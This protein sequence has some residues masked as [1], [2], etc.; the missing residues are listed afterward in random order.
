M[1]RYRYLL[2][3]STIVIDGRV[4]FIKDTRL[5]EDPRLYL[6]TPISTVA[7]AVRGD[8][9]DGARDLMM[10]RRGDNSMTVEL[11]NDARLSSV[12]FNSVGVG[13][14]VVGAGV[15]VVAIV[16]S[17]AARVAGRPWV[18]QGFAKEKRKAVNTEPPT[19][20]QARK[21]W[22]TVN[23]EALHH[24]VKYA[25]VAK[26]G[27]EELLAVRAKLS[28]TKDSIVAAQAARRI[29]Y[30]EDLVADSKAEVAKVDGLYE[31]WSSAHLEK[32][33]Q[34][35]VFTLAID[36]LPIHDD[37]SSFVPAW[38]GVKSTPTIQGPIE[39][40]SS[41]YPAWSDVESTA[42]ID[43]RPT[44][45]DPSSL[46]PARPGVESAATVD[47]SPV[48]DIWETLGVLIE[49]GPVS[50]QEPYRPNEEGTVKGNPDVESIHWR[51]PRLAR[52][53]VWR[54]VG[55]DEQPVLEQMSDILVTDRFSNSRSLKLDGHFF[56]DQ[57]AA[58]TLD[59]L[60]C[61]IKF[62][63]G[64]KGAVGAVADAISAA[65]EQFV[66][67][68]DAVTK[69]STA[70][71]DLSTAGADLRLKAIKRQLDQRTQD[72]EL[73]GLNATAADFAELKRLKQQVEIAEAQ[74]S[75]APPS[76]LAKLEGQLVQETAGRDL[77]A[78]RRDR[79]Q[80]AELGALHGE[81]DLLKAELGLVKLRLPDD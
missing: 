23:K 25:G 37:P 21:A 71:G 53:W 40:D 18:Q 26:T 27:T 43:E 66:A 76:E 63:S 36:E 77:D 56:G 32:H 64:D 1:T 38:P 11:T 42:T 24:Q 45:V 9:S 72:L 13:S 79:A 22:E 54:R 4:E 12:A 80:V 39:V 33:E 67:G 30:L 73:E 57:A 61:P 52:L 59:P 70:L 10:P 6:G 8:S 7:T 78:V 14:K 17:V 34:H 60:G 48:K 50:K 51:D 5:E 74:G 69:A 41:S 2:P 28:K 29:Q 20:E 35:L 68:L 47:E 55:P 3:E 65:P 31:A 58:I 75:L 16:A 81:I 46:D 19:V 15:K 62:V 44:H 49:I